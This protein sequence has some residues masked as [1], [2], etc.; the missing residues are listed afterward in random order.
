[1]WGWGFK[2]KICLLKTQKVVPFFLIFL[3]SLYRDMFHLYNFLK[4]GQLC[5]YNVIISIYLKL[6]KK[7]VI[8]NLYD[9]LSFPLLRICIFKTFKEKEVIYIRLLFNFYNIYLWRNKH[10]PLPSFS[11]FLLVNYSLP[12]KKLP[13]IL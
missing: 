9:S 7:D 1:M 6:T 11:F 13:N 5:P 4:N 8:V 10:F 3:I 2:S 12:P